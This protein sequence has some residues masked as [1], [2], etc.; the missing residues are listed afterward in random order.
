MLN[1]PPRLSRASPIM[2]Q[3]RPDL[4]DSGESAERVA[5]QRAASYRI[6]P[7]WGGSVPA[8]IAGYRVEENQ[9]VRGR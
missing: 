2:V 3:L 7:A 9:T 5:R 6:L 1:P 4:A 8:G